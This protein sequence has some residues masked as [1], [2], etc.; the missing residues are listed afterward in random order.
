MKNS[1]SKTTHKPGIRSLSA[2]AALTVVVLLVLV[3]P[4][5]SLS[6]GIT[7][8]ISGTV[9]DPSGAAIGKATVTI[10]NVDTG[11]TRI[12]QTSDAGTY[13][14][15]QLLPGNY[16]VKVDK[17]GSTRNCRWARNRPRSR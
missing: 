1:A 10:S 8:S 11:A 3:T 5:A 4:Q 7:G 9:T 17:V 13:E 14:V 2:I 12:I 6:Q 16:N 15:T